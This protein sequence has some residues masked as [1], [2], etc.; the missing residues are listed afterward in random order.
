MSEGGSEVVVG[1][2]TPKYNLTVSLWYCS[3]SFW[4]T[5]VT[6]LTKNMGDLSSG[7]MSHP[8]KTKIYCNVL[9]LLSYQLYQR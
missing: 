3:K 9:Q 8:L 2:T 1:Y 4:K 7:S 6:P 5:V